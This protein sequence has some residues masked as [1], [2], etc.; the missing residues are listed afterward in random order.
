MTYLKKK[1]K[2]KK[3]AGRFTAAVIAMGLM[4]TGT[5]YGNTQTYAKSS[6]KKVTLNSSSKKLQ[7]GKSFTLSVKAVSKDV[8]V[9][10]VKF[11]S[12]KRSVA[13][14][15]SKGKV[16]A[17]KEGNT[18]IK[19]VVSYKEKK[20]VKGKKKW[21]D[22]NKTLKCNVT[23]Y[24][25]KVTPTSE[26]TKTP[27][28][29]ETPTSEPTKTPAETETPTSEPTK[30]P[31]ETE[32]P[33]S[34]PTKT[35]VATEK[36][37]A[38]PAAASDAYQ[39]VHD[40]GLGI[41][42]G[43]TM[44]SVAM[45][46]LGSVNAYETY[47]GA[48]TTTKAMVDGMRKAGFKTIRIPV[49]WSNMMSDDGKYTI[50]DAY[51]NR[52]EEI[53]S[54]ALDNDMYVIVNIHYDGGWWARFGSKTQS[55]RI[56]AMEKYKAM[57]TQIAERFNK[58]SD[59]VIFESA[60]EELGTR[61]NSTNDYSGSGYYTNVDD[62][63]KLTNEINQTF[64][65]IVR[66]T[67]GN[68]A[69]RFLLIAGYDTDITKTCDA[70]YQ[71]PKDT[72]ES[73]LMVS[74]HYYSPYGYCDI[75]D[76]SNSLYI[77]SWGSD[78]EVKTLKA[79]LKNM[80][81]RFVDNG[82]PVIIG[83]YNVCDTKNSDGTYTRKTGRDIFIKNV[84]EYSLANGMCPVLWDTGSGYS[85]SQYR[86][87]NDVDK[88]LFEELSVTAEN[89]QV[90]SPAAAEKSYTWTGNIGASGWNA[91]T[92]SATDDNWN[93][94]VNAVGA[95]YKLNGIDWSK[96]KNSYLEIKVNE[97]TIGSSVGYKIAN[98][99]NTENEYYNFVED[100]KTKVSGTF[101]LSNG[102]SLKVD[103]TKRGLTDTDSIYIGMV[104][105]D[106]NANV[107]ITLKDSID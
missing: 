38:E 34:E 54:Y 65:D 23:V 29:T 76:P 87:S 9:K 51:F 40:L 46:K 24:V 79:D 92:P 3:Q 59:K 81:L 25:N 32:V 47:W 67:G 100:S 28:E 49:A 21:K 37:S 58:Y 52:V 27:A 89:S 80:K 61:L 97:L 56:Q 84:C 99:V 11:S 93:L 91:V 105:K 19:C 101:E 22:F 75:S 26:P 104:D 68:N 86:M 66:A 17:L 60:N 45:S 44:E 6:D 90:Y 64:V 107:T 20:N 98:E 102:A 82:Y 88:S 78:E 10:K 2:L 95:A 15:S 96:F 62:L 53:M 16:K 55:E 14:V 71:M 72:I 69:K 94:S 36:P 8:K 13:S 39:M 18:I 103:L 30:T 31:T 73:H 42:L 74:V 43:N 48:P 33:T 83:E 41:N 4:I 7:K 70:R 106:F 12:G 63:Y 77:A 5:F 85:R 35:P 50:S 1:T 57:W